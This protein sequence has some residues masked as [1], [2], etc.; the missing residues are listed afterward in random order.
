MAEDSGL[1]EGDCFGV[2]LPGGGFGVGLVARLGRP[3]LVLGYFAPIRYKQIPS[4]DEINFSA[5]SAVWVKLFGDLGFLD[6]RWPVLG[7][8]TNWDSESW[9]LPDF[10]HHEELTGRCY[11]ISYGGDLRNSPEQ[12]LVPP[13]DIVGLPE[14]GIAGAKFVELKLERLLPAGSN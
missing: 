6:K 4:I 3:G 7:I 9:P 10:S 8:L 14:H 5:E 11:R 13:E 12:M 1:R 2:P